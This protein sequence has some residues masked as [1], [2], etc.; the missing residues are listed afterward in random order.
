LPQLLI[1]VDMNASEEANCA[2]R[3]ANTMHSGSN[4]DQKSSFNKL[5]GMKGIGTP[6]GFLY[7]ENL[8]QKIKDPTRGPFGSLIAQDRQKSL[9]KALPPSLFA[10]PRRNLKECTPGA[11]TGDTPIFMRSL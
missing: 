4:G 8:K 5:F 2:K 11:K 10:K 9:Q 3:W 6:E 7:E 1:E